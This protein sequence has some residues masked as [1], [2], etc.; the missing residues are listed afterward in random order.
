VHSNAAEAAGLT[1]SNR[2]VYNKQYAINITHQHY[3]EREREYD[4][5]RVRVL[6]S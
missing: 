4:G 1:D 6:M 3:I 5:L 2:V